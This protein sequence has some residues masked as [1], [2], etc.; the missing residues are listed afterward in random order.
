MIPA[1]FGALITGIVVSVFTRW[2]LFVHWWDIVKLVL[3]LVVTALST[4]GVGRWIEISLATG[5]DATAR[6]QAPSIT[7]AATVNLFAFLTMTA[8]SIYK[9]RGTR[10]G[11]GRLRRPRRATPSPGDEQSV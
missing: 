1:A 3:T 2:G 10:A 11:A 7:T 4:F 9:P 6:T 5:T 8:L